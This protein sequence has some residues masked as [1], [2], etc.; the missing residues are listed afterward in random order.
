MIDSPYELILFSCKD[1]ILF[2]TNK[3]DTEYHNHHYIQITISLEKNFHIIIEEESFKVDGII[4][5]SNKHHKLHGQKEWQLYL[6]VNPESVFGELLT[7]TFLQDNHYFIL[8]KKQTNLV[9][10]LAAQKLFSLTTPTDYCK[11]IT[12]CKQIL[13]LADIEIEHTL[14]DR[15]QDV[16]TYIEKHPL[17]RL[18]V[19]NLSKMIY[20]SES[21]LSHLF[22]EKMGIALSSYILH[23]KLEMAFHFIFSGF[24]ITAA[25]LEAGFN[26]SSHFTRSVRDKLGMPPRIISQNSRYL[27]VK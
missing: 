14:D 25:A 1:H 18:S 8:E 16:L 5:D 23:H 3:V 2:L 22:K 4:V 17:H 26:S 21:R 7:R 9:Q 20:L 13:G 19:K 6:L 10:Q 11:F 24:S 12:K 27:Q 15:I